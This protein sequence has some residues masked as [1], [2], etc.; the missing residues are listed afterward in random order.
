[1]VDTAIITTALREMA[2][3]EAAHVAIAAALDLGIVAVTII[4]GDDYLGLCTYQPMPPNFQPDMDDAYDED[5]P[6][7][8]LLER[9]ILATM[10]GGLAGQRVTGGYNQVGCDSDINSALQMCMYLTGDPIN[11][12]EKWDELWSRSEALVSE[13]W[14]QIT[15][16]G[17]TL[18]NVGTLDQEAARMI[19]EDVG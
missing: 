12:Q 19:L 7:S 2:Y 17:D 11:L 5:D 18:M 14:P 15:A 9:Y 13:R 1:M 8:S 16:L 4:P 3:H 10:A 6:T